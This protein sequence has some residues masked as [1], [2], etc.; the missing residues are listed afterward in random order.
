MYQHT[1]EHGLLESPCRHWASF[2][3]H[4]CI[5]ALLDSG[6]KNSRSE[7]A[8]KYSKC[9]SKRFSVWQSWYAFEP[10]AKRPSNNSQ[11]LHQA[12]LLYASPFQDFE[13]NQDQ[14]STNAL[15]PRDPRSRL[16]QRDPRRNDFYGAV[17]RREEGYC[18][19]KTRSS[20]QI[21]V[22][23]SAQFHHI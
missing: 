22:H 12:C 14:S 7:K 10:H 16:L 8:I 23:P 18:N 15:V 4:Y 20:K 19:S 5:L 13:T 9:P 2:Q 17:A 11:H 1:S 21:T 6:S 3:V